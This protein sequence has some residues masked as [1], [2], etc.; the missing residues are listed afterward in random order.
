MRLQTVAS[1]LLVGFALLESG[2]ARFKNFNLADSLRGRQNEEEWEQDVD[3]F[4][5]LQRKPKNNLMLADLAPSQ[6]ATTIKARTSNKRD[7][8][9]A[10]QEFNKA[11]DL[12]DRAIKLRGN[13]SDESSD[14]FR[15]AANHFRVAAAFLPESAIEKDSLFFQGES[16]FFADA[17]NQAN[18]A[19][20]WLIEKYPAN[21]YLDKVESRRF[22]IAQYWLQMENKHESWVPNVKFGDSRRPV[23]GLANEARRIFHRIRMD[24]PTGKLADDATF[25]LA[26][27]YFK[28]GRFDEASETY[29]DLRT[30]YPGSTHQFQTHLFELK[31]RLSS[32]H[33]PSYDGQPLEKADKLLKAMMRQFPNEVK[34]HYEYLAREGSRIRDLL[35]ERDWEMAKYYER[36]GENRAAKFYFEKVVR[37]YGETQLAQQAKS[38]IPEL[39]SLPDKPKERA[40]WLSNMF[41]DVNAV[42]PLIASGDNDSI[43][44]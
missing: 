43:F 20:E 41:P 13:Q 23:Q 7:R 3:T 1:I 22:A 26:N 28:A 10:E 15:Q 2:C 35:A 12:Y 25:A 40:K 17:Y 21:Q 27:S 5:P 37:E 30:A 24:D 18:R 39:A 14:L 8:A 11:R 6:I 34:G 44:R 33:G 36:L 9:S 4:D 38:A 32:Y 16:Y 42:K 31:S 29:E 19:Y